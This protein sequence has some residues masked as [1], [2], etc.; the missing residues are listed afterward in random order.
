VILGAVVGLV[1]AIVFVI[2]FWRGHPAPDERY[3]SAAWRDEHLRGRRG[4]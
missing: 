4:E 2:G 1:A 3:V